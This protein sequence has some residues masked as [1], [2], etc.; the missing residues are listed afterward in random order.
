MGSLEFDGGVREHLSSIDIAPFIDAESSEEPKRLGVLK[1]VREACLRHGFFGITGHGISLDLQGQ[2]LEQSKRLFDLTYEE[3]MELHESK[4][5][6]LSHRG[7]QPIQGERLQQGQA[8]DL[9]EGFQ[10]G[11]EKAIDHPDCA[12]E[13]MLTGPNVWP[14]TLGPDFSIIM[15]TYFEKIKA[16][17]D[18]LVKIIAL[19]LN[20]DYDEIFKPLLS[21]SL[22][23]LR[24]LH[25]PPQDDGTKL[26]AGAHTDFGAL[27]CLLTDGVSGLQ[28][29]NDANEWVDVEIDNGSY[30]VNLGDIMK[31]MTAGLYKSSMHRVVNTSGKHRYS[32]PC[33]LDG[34]L[35]FVVTSVVNGPDPEHSSLTIE[36]HMM[37][38][39]G[40]ARIHIVK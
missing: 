22:R 1:Q 25:Y 27:T 4:S 2:V 36:E 28:I 31:R 14:Q 19:T 23:G 5:F 30:V 39:F 16:L 13:R 6:G 24:L 15:K 26:G 34:N 9:K 40:T 21:D 12:A 38:R 10:L 8:P 17:Q 11:V 37:E 18:T 29:M 35:D 20:V 33:F 32:V 7:Y 3:K